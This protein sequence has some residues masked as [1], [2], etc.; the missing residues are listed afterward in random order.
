MYK[1]VD[2]R[3]RA[4]L[5]HHI[6]E[7]YKTDVP[8]VTERPPRRAMGEVASPVCFEL[9]K[10][11]KKPPRALAQ[12]IANSL[13]PIPGVARVEVAGG[14]YLNLFLDRAAFFRAACDEAR[15]EGPRI[16]AP[17]AP[18][19]MV[20]HTSINPNKAAHIG[21]LRNAVLGDTFV[22]LLR[23]S[24]G[25][26]EVHNYIDNTGVQVAD[27]VL[28]FL[29]PEPKSL[30]QVREL[31]AAP[32]FDYF[33]WDLYTRVT[34]FL[35][36]DKTRLELRSQTLKDIE[37]GR[38]DAAKMAEVVSTAIVRCHLKTL[39]RL[40]IDYDLLSRESEILHLKFWDAAFELL[41]QRGAIQ[42]AS[43]GKNTGCWVMRLPS[44]KN[45]TGGE[46][47]AGAEEPAELADAK[48]IVRSN[49]TVTYVGKDIAYHLWKFGLL[50]R[51]F[52]YR[53]FHTHPDAHEVW[54]TDSNSDDP[55]APAFGHAREVFN[56]IDTR[57]AYP[58][59]VVVAGLRALGYAEEA[60][61]L[62]HFAYNVV[63]L[64]PRCAQDLGYEIPAED[65]KK[66]YIEVSG[67]KGQG[68][69]AD[70]LIDKL[71]RAAGKE[72]AER[73][74]ELVNTIGYHQTVEST[75]VAALRYYLL[76]FTRSTVIAFD[77]E[78]AVSFEGETGPYLQYALVRVHGIWR[79]GAERNPE[80]DGADA[81]KLFGNYDPAKFLDAPADE[82]WEVALQAGSLDARVD[83]AIGAQEP[84]FLARYAFEL[85]QAFNVFYHK[86][87]ILS[88]E[89]DEKRAFLLMLTYLVHKQLSAALGL[90]GIPV[91]ERM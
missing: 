33:C 56:V 13:K 6:H 4:A 47:G 61:H 75:A 68:V 70:D 66:P 27:V 18:K 17:D 50:G 48:I 1:A 37:E 80:F 26:V 12:E 34:Q 14:G 44:D 49:G 73:H 59:E 8:V 87:H 55:G 64:T 84:A 10:R 28:G 57:Q 83:A 2:D 63:A 40:G 9:A 32:K 16:P 76:R 43:S 36:E 23:Y 82:I 29:H 79:K 7:R 65:A 53:R 15:R 67:R 5:R 74:P 60:D 51:D 31:A 35:A 81:A 11:L 90:L 52:H 19:V 88:E 77:F 24:G 85:A 45:A 22:R 78:K 86:H 69:K 42:L 39:D 41:K 89:N 62:Q 46:E 72:T 3:I 91:A 25:R 58:Q 54:T 38:G 20:E 21:H 30:D 71:I